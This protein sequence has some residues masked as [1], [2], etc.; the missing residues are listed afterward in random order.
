[1]NSPSPSPSPSISAQHRPAV[2]KIIEEE[3]ARELNENGFL[4]GKIPQLLLANMLR[5]ANPIIVRKSR[6]NSANKY[7]NLLHFISM[8]WL[9]ILAVYEEVSYHG[10]DQV[11]HLIKDPALKENTSRHFVSVLLIFPLFSRAKPFLFFL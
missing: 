10:L 7:W 3:Q 9:G 6:P 5:K 1:M 4:G 8:L 2:Q 11:V